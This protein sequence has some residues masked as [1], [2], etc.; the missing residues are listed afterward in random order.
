MGKVLFIEEF[1]RGAHEEH[2]GRDF[3]K[4][5]AAVRAHEGMLEFAPIRENIREQAK[6]LSVF[7]RVRAPPKPKD[8]DLRLARVS[9][10]IYIIDTLDKILKHADAS[11]TDS[12]YTSF[13]SARKAARTFLDDAYFSKNADEILSCYGRC[14]ATLVQVGSKCGV[15]VLD[16]EPAV[17]S[18][19]MRVAEM[20]D[21]INGYFF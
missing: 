10:A 15:Q 14:E 5:P 4:R 12:L 6:A 1:Q 9:L 20:I 7:Y 19:K 2:K 11:D 17:E 8:F 3:R 18:T 16:P 13:D 21:Q